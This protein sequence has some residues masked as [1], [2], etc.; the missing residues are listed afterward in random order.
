M[1]RRGGRP[2]AALC[3][4]LALIVVLTWAV[5][6]AVGVVEER[7]VRRYDMAAADNLLAR[8]AQTGWR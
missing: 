5:L 7:I 1:A 8:K 4:L 3:V 2:L 6:G